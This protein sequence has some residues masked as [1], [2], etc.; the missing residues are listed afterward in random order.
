KNRVAQTNELLCKILAYNLTVLI[1][2]MHENGLHLNL[3]GCTQTPLQVT[4]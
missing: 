2:E 1:H 3:A 4:P